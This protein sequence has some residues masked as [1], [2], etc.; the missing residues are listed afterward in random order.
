MIIQIYKQANE[1]PKPFLDHT[2][3]LRDAK[4]GHPIAVSVRD[5]SDEEQELD[6]DM[7]G[8][9]FFDVVSILAGLLSVLLD[10][11]HFRTG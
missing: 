1:P 2:G 6:D 3:K 10:A 8:Y 7:A 11:D 4:T 5:G 9:S